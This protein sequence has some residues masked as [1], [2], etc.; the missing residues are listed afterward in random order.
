MCI[1]IGCILQFKV[2][3]RQLVL[4]HSAFAA[5]FSGNHVVME[6]LI[7]EFQDKLESK[8]HQRNDPPTWLE[9]LPSDE[10]AGQQ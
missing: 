8:K 9:D 1:I 3:Q 7:K 6:T 4:L 2:M 5:Y 10:G